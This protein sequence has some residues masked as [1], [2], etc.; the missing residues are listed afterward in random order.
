MIADNPGL[1]EVQ[2]EGRI[3]LLC[4][5]EEN[6][7]AILDPEG[8]SLD[9][10]LGPRLVGLLE[11]DHLDTFLD[12]LNESLSYPGLEDIHR[13]QLLAAVAARKAAR[14]QR[15]QEIDDVN[16][17]I[18]IGA[19]ILSLLPEHDPRCALW[20]EYLVD[21]LLSRFKVLF[22]SED[23]NLAVTKARGLV[24][25]HS[26]REHARYLR[27]LGV[28]LQARFDEL[29]DV[30]DIESAVVHQKEAL[31]LYPPDHPD[32]LE[33]LAD[34]G[35]SSLAVFEQRG[36]T[37]F[38]DSS[39]NYYTLALTLCSPD[40]PDRGRHLGNL[41]SAIQTQFE[42]SGNSGDLEKAIELY[43]ES[44][45]FF[46]PGHR[47]RERAIDSLGDA[48]RTRWEE[49]RNPE[50]I[51]SA[52]TYHS[53]A[54]AQNSRGPDRARSLI[55]YGSALQARFDDRGAAEDL[56]SAIASYKE[57]IEVLPTGHHYLGVSINNL[58]NLFWSRF[59]LKGIME[60]LE[61]AIDY[62]TQL[63]SYTPPGHPDI[64]KDLNNLASVLVIRFEQHGGLE[65][66]ESAIAYR[67]KA[68]ELPN[69][70]P[71][72]QLVLFGN[73]GYA[74]FKRYE[75]LQTLEDLELAITYHTEAVA[76]CPSDHSTR[77]THLDN[78][79]TSLGARIEHAKSA[80]DIDAIIKYATE[81]LTLRSKDHPKRPRSLHNLGTAYQARFENLGQIEDLHRAIAYFTEAQDSLSPFHPSEAKYQTYLASLLL[82]N[83]GPLGTSRI[84]E[85]F[86]RLKK[87]ANQ[88]SAS[89]QLRFDTARTWLSYGR[90]YNHP[91]LLDAYVQS[92]EN[93]RLCLVMRPTLD[94]QHQFLMNIP[95][96]LPSE[97]AST[98]IDANQLDKATELLEEGW[99]ILWSRLSGYR[100][101]IA[102]LSLVDSDLA[103]QFSRLSAELES[104]AV[105]SDTPLTLTTSYNDT[106]TLEN[107]MRQHR[108][109]SERW[110][111]TLKQIRQKDDFTR[112]LLPRPFASLRDAVRG[113]PV[114]II[115]VSK[116][117]TDALL[118]LQNE[119]LPILIPLPN[120]S[121]AHLE[122]LS[123]RL[124]R[125][126]K[127]HFEQSYNNVDA[128]IKFILTTLWNTVI[129]PIVE[130]L[131]AAGLT[132]CT[133]SRI[134]LCP[135]SVLCSLPIHAAGPYDEGRPCLS[136][137]FVCSYTP[138][139]SALIKAWSTTPTP[140]PHVLVVDNP[141]GSLSCADLEVNEIRRYEK[142]T[143]ILVLSG[144]QAN[145][146]SVT[147]GLQQHPWVHFV[148]HGFQDPEPY[149][150][151]LIL[152]DEIYLTALDIVQARLPNAEFA[153]LSACETA[154]GDQKGT[155]DEVIHL[156]SS[157]QFSGFR[158]VVGTLWPMMDMD[159]P[160][161]ARTF[162]R[163]MFRNGAQKVDFRDAA[164]AIQLATK[165]L[166]RKKWMTMDRWI[167][168]IHVGA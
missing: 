138:S 125:A 108:L 121:H 150:S 71:P 154:T 53:E 91:S 87:A 48:L 77:A 1:I 160:M 57:S 93:L 146:Q 7:G 80:V 151:S 90:Q 104:L 10:I 127:M 17:V 13:L 126:L 111:E 142:I 82:D 113:M 75:R 62:F 145:Q 115:N 31:E 157:L 52:I 15:L 155:P 114:I 26:P 153:F 36:G 40:H 2:Y 11:E 58:G 165:A 118:I 28:A 45:T 25:L 50:D 4:H 65:D 46:P 49:Y 130:K 44:L 79:V 105:A 64:V 16:S 88:S 100:S 106:N 99:G 27:K 101:S 47:S 42:H 141:D 134:W 137:L 103:G 66:L 163:H 149:K 69:T 98:A 70:F 60:D 136:D 78:L 161:V 21:A 132:V 97:A 96:S 135:T 41:G 83:T 148:C 116:Y 120:A 158:S 9:V 143:P 133:G 30:G 86:T 54:L 51:D 35:K 74:L 34:L 8:A 56:D 119:E 117:R 20:Q 29:G 124:S 43:R 92:I 152:H 159:G 144:E 140:S 156:A 24:S 59:E 109:V 95:I 84:E 14:F 55:L 107:R 81:S 37:E 39:I 131:E 122:T 76:R 38:L 67:R 162:Y 164:T 168:F 18:F 32:R 166:R 110:E 22:C 33:L 72:D 63:L 73:F 147:C 3:G 19:E 6:W 68:L 85:G 61:T 94:M 12:F 139:L 23:L 112:F 123:V 128:E 102:D 5:G 129:S 167:N 89:S